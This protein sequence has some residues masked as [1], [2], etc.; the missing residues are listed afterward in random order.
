MKRD[1]RLRVVQSEV[2]VHESKRTFEPILQRGR[3]S[4]GVN[5]NVTNPKAPK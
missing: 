2:N 3:W 4:A 1:L 5:P